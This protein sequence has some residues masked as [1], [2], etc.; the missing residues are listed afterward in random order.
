MKLFPRSLSTD[1]FTNLVAEGTEINGAV[2]FSGV[3]QVEGHVKGDIISSVPETGSKKQNDCI[4]VTKTGE[5]SSTLIRAT[6]VVISGKITSK[7]IFAEDTLRITSTAKIKG[8]TLSYRRLEIEPGADI[9]DC[10]LKN[11]NSQAEVVLDDSGNP[12]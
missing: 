3:I 4:N 11:L 8:A 6:N 1:S 2:Y 5:V 9:D 10:V 12:V 7:S